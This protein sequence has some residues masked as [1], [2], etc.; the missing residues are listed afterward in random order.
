MLIDDDPDF[1]NIVREQLAD[2]PGRLAGCKI[3][4]ET[5]PIKGIAA[6][7]RDPPTVILLDLKLPNVDGREVLRL[8]REDPRTRQ[9][10]VV[11]ASVREDVRET[12]QEGATAALCKPVD[13][14]GLISALE[15][16]VS[17]S[18][19]APHDE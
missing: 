13:R 16:A 17:R 15:E 12:L 5:N 11:I 8:L 9:V 3:Q 7:R 10:P 6:A 1:V 18:V 14:E 2:A 19:A 4:S